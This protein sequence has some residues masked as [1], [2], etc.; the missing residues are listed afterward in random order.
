MKTRLFFAIWL[1]PAAFG[2]E[3]VDFKNPR[4]AGLTDFAAPGA[5]SSR[6]VSFLENPGA[7]GLPGL[8]EQHL[9]DPYSVLGIS[10]GAS[11]NEAR[12]AYIKKSFQWHPDRN[13]SPEAGAVFF[14]IKT[15]YEAVKAEIE[16]GRANP[17]PDILHQAIRGALVSI[18]HGQQLFTADREL[19]KT[20]ELLLR[21]PKIRQS[22]N[23]A[24][25]ASAPGGPP[26][27][28]SH[29]GTPLQMALYL[30]E[31][32]ALLLKNG[33]DPEASGPDLL[34][35]AEMLLQQRSAFF[36]VQLRSR[37]Q[38]WRPDNFAAFSMLRRHGKINLN[39]TSSTGKT[40][41]WMIFD[42]ITSLEAQSWRN[43]WAGPFGQHDMSRGPRTC[44]P[45]KRC[46]AQKTRR[47]YCHSCDSAK[48]AKKWKKL[49]FQLIEEGAD[50][51][52]QN[53][54]GQTI[55]AAAIMRRNAISQGLISRWGSSI[56]W[57]REDSAGRTCL[58]LAIDAGDEKTALNA[59]RAGGADMSYRNR[60]GQSYLEL[61][62]DSDFRKLADFLEQNEGFLRLKPNERERVISLAAKRRNYPFLK[63]IQPLIS[64]DSAPKKQLPG[65]PKLLTLSSQPKRESGPV[66]AN[67]LR[68]C[69]QAVFLI[70]AQIM[71]RPA[72]GEKP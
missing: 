31:S 47:V 23:N 7:S 25:S 20:L 17:D 24:Q 55:L 41:L 52:A 68:K 12:K 1:V 59:A 45:E 44:P 48:E 18:V 64:G 60:H 19:G 26:P 32:A 2:A 4:A 56:D 65:R 35:P 38:P 42:I 63:K 46:A 27:V 50:L 71:G 40:L 9:S 34:P 21:D 28:Y 6:A 51:N 67:W 69:R 36:P 58:H 33:A 30:P 29:R 16:G 43:P 54:K 8:A 10:K 57:D 53:S 3:P 39:R 62:V 11:L 61:A 49:F 13:P 66:F 70:K 15:A 37:S 72:G 5:L 14:L 22:I